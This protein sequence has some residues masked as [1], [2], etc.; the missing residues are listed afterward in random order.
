MKSD[1]RSSHLF[2][3]KLNQS[4]ALSKLFKQHVKLL[5]KITE[6]F[7]GVFIV[8][9]SRECHAGS[10]VKGVGVDGGEVESSR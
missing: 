6:H 4:N 2:S 8:K 1:P 9:R 7:R 5:R 3:C 10:D